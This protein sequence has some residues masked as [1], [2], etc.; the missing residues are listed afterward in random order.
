MHCAPWS[1]MYA[2]PARKF[3]IQPGKSQADH[4][5][6]PDAP[7]T[8]PV[9]WRNLQHPWKKSR[10]RSARVRS[11]PRKL[12]TWPAATHPPR[13]KV[14]KS[15]EMSHK[16]W[17]ASAAHRTRSQKSLGRLMASLFKPISLHSTLPLKPR[18]PVNKV[19]VSLSW[20]RKY[21]RCHSV[22]QQLPKKSKI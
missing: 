8:P 1:D 19:V 7:S 9:T 6:F 3:S 12:P 2:N 13:L 21:E 18:V 17:R 11:I 14:V 4:K 22:R 16:P 20:P 5:I 15:C 10:P